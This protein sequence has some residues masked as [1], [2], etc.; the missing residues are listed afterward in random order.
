M[1]IC[2]FSAVIIT[3]PVFLVAL[4]CILAMLKRHK[5]IVYKPHSGGVILRFILGLIAVPELNINLIT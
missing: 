4:C 2:S 5:E 3:F 1:D